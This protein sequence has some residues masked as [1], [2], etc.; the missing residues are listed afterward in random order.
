MKNSLHQ[1]NSR[2]G[3]IGKTTKMK[4]ER[5]KGKRAEQEANEKIPSSLKFL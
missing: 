4:H 3:T 5:Q 2:L 1:I